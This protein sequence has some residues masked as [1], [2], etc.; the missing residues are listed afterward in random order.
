MELGQSYDTASL[1]NLHDV[2]SVLRLVLSRPEREPQNGGSWGFLPPEKQL[3]TVVLGFKRALS[4]GCLGRGRRHRRNINGRNLHCHECLSV[5]RQTLMVNGNRHG[6]VK[7]ELIGIGEV[8]LPPWL[9]IENESAKETPSPPPKRARFPTSQ[10]P[11][12]DNAGHSGPGLILEYL[13]AD[14]SHAPR[15]KSVRSTTPNLLE[16]GAVEC[17]GHRPETL[18]KTP[19][20]LRS[21]EDVEGVRNSFKQSDTGIGK[22]PQLNTTAF[23]ELL[24]RGTPIDAILEFLENPI[25]SSPDD[26]NLEC[27]LAYRIVCLSPSSNEDERLVSWIQTRIVLGFLPLNSITP[28]L[29]VV[30]RPSNNRQGV[31]SRETFYERIAEAVWRC[32]ISGSPEVKQRTMNIFLVFIACGKLTPTLESL[33]WELVGDSM[34]DQSRLMDEGICAFIDAYMLAQTPLHNSTTIVADDLPRI[35]K[36]LETART[37]PDSLAEACLVSVSKALIDRCTN[38]DHNTTSEDSEGVSE[39]KS[40]VKRLRKWWTLLQDSGVMS[41][42]QQRPRWQDLE[43]TL[44]FHAHDVLIT[45]LQLLDQSTICRFLIRHCHVPELKRKGH[46]L[47]GKHANFRTRAENQFDDIC[48]EH[49]NRPP[50]INLL[51]TI[52][53]ANQPGIWTI[54]KIIDIV[55]SLGMTGTMLHLVANHDISHVRFDAEVVRDEIN[56]YLRHDEPRTAYQLFQSFALLPLEHVPE[57][58]EAMIANSNLST[59]T[60]LYYRH[61]RQKWVEQLQLFHC[62][63]EDVKRLRVQLL[64][65]MAYAFARS[66]HH[67]RVS[68]RQVYKCYIA[69]KRDSLS[70]TP[71]MTKALTY[72]GVVRYLKL[73][74]WVSTARYNKIWSLVREVEGQKVADRLDDLVFFWRGKVLDQNMYRKR[75]ERA[76]GLPRG[77]LLP[78]ELLE[79]LHA[80]TLPQAPSSTRRTWQKR[81]HWYKRESSDPHECL[82]AGDGR[83]MVW[84]PTSVPWT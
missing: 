54:H 81:M 68:F 10:S 2:M 33:G 28:L 36:V 29:E 38:P 67:P 20:D 27:L 13:T 51:L 40:H 82:R 48:R 25:L 43:H 50:F 78:D 9:D 4:R 8:S 59:H 53:L 55:Q 80:N 66:S 77:A 31:L 65:R 61:R 6:T 32:G 44:G 74:A 72:A 5:S 73:G 42:L 76:M 21:C 1:R 14:D 57:L 19:C 3:H 15:R 75:K 46:R 11:T 39:R 45:Y 37:F 18:L 70:V 16:A 49:P 12:K 30:N 22:R 7:S 60:A 47:P 23:Q 64:N 79:R 34:S 17:I 41:E 84:K 62:T 26:G 69:F 52:R 24:E 56:Y 63:P 83:N 71:A 58:A 35:S